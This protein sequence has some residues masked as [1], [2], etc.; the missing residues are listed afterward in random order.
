MGDAERNLLGTT[1]RSEQ[2]CKL[3]DLHC[4]FEDR[5]LEVG[6]QKKCARPSPAPCHTSRV[7]KSAFRNARALLSHVGL[8]C[9]EGYNDVVAL[10]NTEALRRSLKKLDR[11]SSRVCMNLDVTYTRSRYFSSAEKKAGGSFLRNKRA[12]AQSLLDLDDD[13]VPCSLLEFHAFL[14]GLGWPANEYIPPDIP[15][16]AKNVRDDG[17]LSARAGR[18]ASIAEEKRPSLGLHRLVGS[19][20]IEN[21]GNLGASSGVE[22]GENVLQYTDFGHVLNIFVPCWSFL[23]TQL[24]LRQS[25]SLP[26]NIA[27]TVE[28]FDETAMGAADSGHTAPVHVVWNDSMCRFRPG[29]DAWNALG[30]RQSADMIIII[31]PL[32]DQLS[33]CA[34]R[35]VLSDRLKTSAQVSALFHHSDLLHHAGAVHATN[36]EDLIIGPL[37]D[38][39]VI[40]LNLL[41]TLVRRTAMN[42]HR[43][44][45]STSFAVRRTRS[46]LQTSGFVVAKNKQSRKIALASGDRRQRGSSLGD[47]FSTSSRTPSRDGQ[48]PSQ[49]GQN[50]SS[51]LD[52]VHV[53]L[54]PAHSE[55]NAITLDSLQGVFV[56]KT[57]PQSRREKMIQRI[58]NHHT[59][60]FDETSIASK[61]HRQFL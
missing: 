20:R 15:E 58:S 38:G 44:L 57:T 54:G 23:N 8:L 6:S 5:H 39:M 53:R 4:D 7:E 51:S 45:D 16:P 12:V 22:R 27:G 43:H 49:V 61:L 60:N 36:K 46:R 32:P 52:A 2:L 55:S 28:R 3:F 25:T 14:A 59:V 9:M 11:I 10:L 17:P 30:L 1:A 50:K 56:G 21:A 18:V 42:V 31:D 47:F 24:D 26:Q 37:M 33:L 35:I 48:T 13:T 41:P 29:T 34:V 40:R 19:M